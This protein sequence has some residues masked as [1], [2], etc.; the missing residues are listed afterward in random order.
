MIGADEHRLIVDVNDLRAFDNEL[1][2]RCAFPCSQ[3][4]T[5]E[6]SQPAGC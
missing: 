4:R 2:R 3:A 1:L 6:C 5:R